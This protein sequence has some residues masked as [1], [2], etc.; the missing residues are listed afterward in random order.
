MTSRGFSGA[1]AAKEYLIDRIV[2]RAKQ[3]GVEL[4]EIERKMLY[5]TETGWTLPDMA[6]V[7]AK[8]DQEYDQDEYEDKIARIVRRVHETATPEDEQAWDDAVEVLRGQDHYL[9]VLMNRKM[10]RKAS[11]RPPGDML[12]LILTAAL[13]VAALMIGIWIFDKQK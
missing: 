2:V 6:E 13:I 4:S 9:L 12:K 3:D 8:F 11:A 10:V 7:S 1:R 5:F